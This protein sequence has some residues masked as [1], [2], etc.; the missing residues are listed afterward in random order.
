L[1]SIS[2]ITMSAEARGMAS[3]AD[4]KQNVNEFILKIY[5]SNNCATAIPK[6]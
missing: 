2:L 4:S 6:Q 1:T 3:R 5:A